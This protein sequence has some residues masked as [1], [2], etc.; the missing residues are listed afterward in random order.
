MMMRSAAVVCCRSARSSFLF[1]AAVTALA[2][3]KA[4]DFGKSIRH[5]RR[6]DER[7]VNCL[8]LAASYSKSV[9]HIDAHTNLQVANQSFSHKL[10]CPAGS[11]SCEM[12]PKTT[13]MMTIVSPESYWLQQRLQFLVSALLRSAKDDCNNE[14]KPETVL[15]ASLLAQNCGFFISSGPQQLL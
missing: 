10:R 7:K 14:G 12:P 9:T 15:H 5:A 2:A 3:V 1:Q 11:S 8:C 4:S 6:R 13:L